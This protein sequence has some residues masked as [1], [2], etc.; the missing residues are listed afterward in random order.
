MSK[1]RWLNADRGVP[2]MAV[3]NSGR[4][5]VHAPIGPAWWT[6]GKWIPAEVKK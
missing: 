2:E 5:S 6:D 3:K 1:G 4:P